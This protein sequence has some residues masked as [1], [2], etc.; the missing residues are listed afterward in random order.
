MKFV[1]TIHTRDKESLPFDTVYLVRDNWDDFNYK[2]TYQLF[3][4]D[5]NGIYSDIGGVKFGKFGLKDGETLV[6]VPLQFDQLDSTYFSLGTDRGY[7]EKLQRL[8]DSV[9]VEILRGLNDLAIDNSKLEEALR[10]K[11]TVK[12]LLRDV[13]KLSVKGQFRRLALGKKALSPFSFEFVRVNLSQDERD[14]EPLFFNVQPDSRP[15]SNLHVLIGSNG[16]GKSYCLASMIQSIVGNQKAPLK[17][18]FIERNTDDPEEVFA[19]LIFVGF[20]AFDEKL[21]SATESFLDRDATVK[22]ERIGVGVKRGIKHEMILG[23]EPEF[24][25]FRNF[26]LQFKS[27]LETCLRNRTLDRWRRIMQHLEIDPVLLDCGLSRLS[28][29]EV[30]TELPLEIFRSLSSGHKIICLAVSRLVSLVAERTLVLIDEPEA[31]LHP[32]LLSS[33][34]RAISA[35]MIEQNGVSIIATHSPVVLQEV[36][37]EC[38]WILRRSGSIYSA[39][40]PETETFGESVGA[41]T[42]DVFNLQV[43]NSGFNKLLSDSVESGD[44]YEGIL[45]EFGGKLG[46]EARALVRS[47]VETKRRA[48]D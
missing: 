28:D 12:S 38:V 46:S 31:H 7:Y 6:E 26:E 34:I 30:E 16:V 8:G 35:L 1:V 9:R 18:V 22:F 48:D 2:T 11:V 27:G 21:Y 44:S 4:I 3:Y 42:R 14:G 47:L 40:R 10:E 29:D 19:N 33:F 39:S 45:A 36:P 32:P 13:S 15:P 43:V 17:G 24:L 23:G 25:L 41:L 5:S 20:S 37:A